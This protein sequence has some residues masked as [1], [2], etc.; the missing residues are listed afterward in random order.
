MEG[1]RIINLHKLKHHINQLTIHSAQCRGTMTLPSTSDIFGLVEYKNPYS[2]R[3]KSIDEACRCKNFCLQKKEN[4]DEI[5][6]TLKK[7]HDYYY[8]VQCQMYCNEREWCDF[9][10]C[11]ENDIHVERIYRNTK[12]WDEQLPILKSFYFR[13]LLPELSCPRYG[14]G[15]IREPPAM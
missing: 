5:Q 14:K 1:S 3:D 11:T 2:V 6:Y 13:A 9:V 7:R 15:T 12:W 10:L 8:Q 4:N